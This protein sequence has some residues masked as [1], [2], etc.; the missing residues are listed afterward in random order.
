MTVLHPASDE[1]GSLTRLLVLASLALASAGAAEEACRIAARGW[2][3]LRHQHPREAERLTAALHTLTREVRF[4]PP[5]QGE[6][7]HE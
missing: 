2:S 3:L 7:D 6:I 1:I 4:D 5:S